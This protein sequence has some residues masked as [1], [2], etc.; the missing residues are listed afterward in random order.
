MRR[1]QKFQI[2]LEGLEFPLQF[3]IGASWCV[4]VKLCPCCFFSEC[5]M[6]LSNLQKEYIPNHYPDLEI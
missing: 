5:A 2:E 4:R 6:G 3:Q 1:P